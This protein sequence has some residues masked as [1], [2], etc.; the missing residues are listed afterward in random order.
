MEELNGYYTTCGFPEDHE[1][2]VS[3]P[4]DPDINSDP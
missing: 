4:E 3:S 2:H 1:P